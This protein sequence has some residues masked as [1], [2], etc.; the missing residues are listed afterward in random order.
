MIAST[1]SVLL[2]RYRSRTVCSKL[3]INDNRQARHCTHD[4]R[5]DRP[6]RACAARVP[7]LQCRASRSTGD[8][9]LPTTFGRRCTV[10]EMQRGPDVQ[11]SITTTTAH[12]RNRGTSCC[13]SGNNVLCVANGGRYTRGT[14]KRVRGCRRSYGGKRVAGW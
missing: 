3:K 7:R 2:Y 6:H 11:R 1:E 12:H 10:G 4:R 5:F 13:S 14:R 9:L 8:G